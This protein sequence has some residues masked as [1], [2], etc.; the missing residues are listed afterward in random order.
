MI[1][2]ILYANIKNN[3]KLF[4]EKNIGICKKLMFDESFLKTISQKL[5]ISIDNTIGCKIEGASVFRDLCKL[6]EHFLSIGLEDTFL[7]ENS[8]KQEFYSQSNI[9]NNGQVSEIM[10][11][12]ENFVIIL[13]LPVVFIDFMKSLLSNKSLNLRN[14]SKILNSI[15]ILYQTKF[16]SLYFQIK[17]SLV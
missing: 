8:E 6:F 4:L 1:S 14:V 3:T 12:I 5:I 10:C 13:N 15:I 2:R 11:S 7:N 17:A 16:K 9:C